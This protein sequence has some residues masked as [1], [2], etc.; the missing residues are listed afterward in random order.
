MSGPCSPLFPIDLRMVDAFSGIVKLSG[1]N[2]WFDKRGY[3]WFEW[4]F[5]LSDFFE[6]GKP[7]SFVASKE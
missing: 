3:N 2:R 5:V 7:N 6:T 1:S 4:S